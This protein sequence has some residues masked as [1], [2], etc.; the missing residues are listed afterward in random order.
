MTGQRLA[1]ALFP[2]INRIGVMIDHGDALSSGIQIR[3]R[4]KVFVI[5]NSG[6]LRV[7]HGATRERERER[8]SKRESGR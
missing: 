8:E 7:E 6:G 4:T 3:P 2:T 1:F 5:S